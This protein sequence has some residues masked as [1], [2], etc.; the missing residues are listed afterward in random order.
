MSGNSW[1]KQFKDIMLKANYVEEKS[2]IWASPLLLGTSFLITSVT[3]IQSTIICEMF[4]ARNGRV[5]V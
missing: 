2:E 4:I 3:L 5:I 1:H